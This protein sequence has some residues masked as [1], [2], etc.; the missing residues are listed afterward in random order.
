MKYQVVFHLDDDSDYGVNITLNNIENLIADMGI[1]NV[2]IEVVTYGRGVN[3]LKRNSN[4]YPNR[5]K[6]LINNKIQFT[7]CSNTVRAMNLQEKD[8]MDGVVIVR[9]GIGELVRK[10]SEGWLYIRP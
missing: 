6:K 4:T 9:S 5:I 2:E 10:Q 7:A 1:D 3:I 8:L